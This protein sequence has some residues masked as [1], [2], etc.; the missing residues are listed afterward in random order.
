MT[1]TPKIF[2]A[3]MDGRKDNNIPFSD[4]QKLLDVLGF[5]YRVR[6]SHYVYWREGVAEI[7]NIQSDNGKAKAYQ[8]KQVR[9]IIQK[10]KLT[11]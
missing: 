7:I 8:V 9:G 11:F 1:S 4:L 2:D 5:S 10:Y 6:G 3:I